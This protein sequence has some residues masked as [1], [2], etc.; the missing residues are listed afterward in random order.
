MPKFI[1]KTPVTI[2]VC[3]EV[4]AKGEKDAIRKADE[5]MSEI[6]ALF[7]G[8]GD[9]LSRPSMAGTEEGAWFEDLDQNAIF[10][11]AE[12]RAEEEE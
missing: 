6:T 7:S 9:D 1:V 3:I 10:L 4:S 2:T 12:T 5:A 8:C 11:S